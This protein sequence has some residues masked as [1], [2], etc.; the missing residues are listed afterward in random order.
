MKAFTTLSALLSA[1]GLA[2][3]HYTFDRLV[4]NG[5]ETRSWEYIREN[6]RAE[7]YMPT[8]FKNTEGRVTPNDADFRCNE[9]S[10]TNAGKTKV[11][12]VAPG[13]ELSMVLAYGARMEHPGPGK[14]PA[15]REHASASRMF[16]L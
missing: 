4:V 9:G 2:Q 3:A 16:P 15:L 6:T 7:K 14:S 1:A 13:D 10:F 12:E 8:K 5:Q 11:F